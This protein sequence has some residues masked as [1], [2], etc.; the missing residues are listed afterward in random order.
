M[1][2]NGGRGKHE[3]PSDDLRKWGPTAP[4]MAGPLEGSQSL[5]G[6][7]TRYV[8]DP[9]SQRVEGRATQTVSM[10]GERRALS[11]TPSFSDSL[12][13]SRGVHHKSEVR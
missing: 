6:G 10:V 13:E 12:N 11:L 4:D 1:R 7:G 9:V 8:R 5:V 2:R 3:D